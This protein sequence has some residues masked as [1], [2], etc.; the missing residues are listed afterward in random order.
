MAGRHLLRAVP[1]EGWVPLWVPSLRRQHVLLGTKP[2]EG[3]L[4]L[5]QHCNTKGEGG[6]KNSFHPDKL[7][8]GICETK[9]TC[10]GKQKNLSYPSDSKECTGGNCYLGQVL[11]ISFRISF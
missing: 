3:F 2:S 10:P 1:S 11:T 7:K 8:F 4:K 6:E 9:K 5:S